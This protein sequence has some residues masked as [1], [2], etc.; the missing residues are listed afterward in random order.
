MHRRRCIGNIQKNEITRY[1]F[2][3]DCCSLYNCLRTNHSNLHG[4]KF[5]THIY[6][7]YWVFSHFCTLLNSLNK[8]QLNKTSQLTELICV[9]CKN[10]AE[11]IKRRFLC[12]LANL[13]E[14][15]NNFLRVPNLV[16]NVARSH[17]HS[18][19]DISAK[20]ISVS[21]SE[22]MVVSRHFA[23]ESMSVHSSQW[24]WKTGIFYKM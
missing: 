5:L 12:T 8:K 18:W 17:F 1:L 15:S 21:A 20:S 7:S 24:L 11:S 22:N 10:A 6:L 16:L 19:I 2:A 23:Y 3:K 9:D 4:W 14:E 13:A